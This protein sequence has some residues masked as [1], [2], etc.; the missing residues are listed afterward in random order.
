MK[1]IRP[2]VVAMILLIAVVA[3]CGQPGGAGG[4]GDR[5]ESL[6]ALGYTGGAEEMSMAPVG[7]VAAA[8]APTAQEQPLPGSQRMLTRR[9]SLMLE[10]DDPRGLAEKAQRLTTA[11]GGH[12][13]SFSVMEMDQ[14]P[15][16]SLV[17]RLP[18]DHLDAAV[19]ELQS[20]AKKVRVE[21]WTTDDV[22]SQV[23]D[24][25]ARVRALELTESELEKLLSE[26][27][28]SK[29]DAGGIMQIFRELSN[30]RAQR[31]SLQT[32]LAHLQDLVALSTIHLDVTPS[33]AVDRSGDSWA[34]GETVQRAFRS[35]V[36][37]AQ[38]VTRGLI[39]FVVVWL[40]L[41]LGVALL[42]VLARGLW[43]RL[44]RAS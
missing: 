44:R 20:A 24:M 41:L 38:A 5:S 2:M 18:A 27:R 19:A 37:A 15:H 39:Y 6:K 40:P 8:P 42:A 30:I 1:T 31:E 17:L 7:R 10:S 9:V 33:A 23:V 22:T 14:G 11:A 36:S 26:S 35:L 4:Q 12:V 43:R 25:A 3:G 29:F 34:L 32:S 21:N 28:S 13:E 16:C